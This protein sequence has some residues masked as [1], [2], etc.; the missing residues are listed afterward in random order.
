MTNSP[1]LIFPDPIQEDILYTEPSKYS[2]SGIL[3]QKKVIK[4][5]AEDIT[6]LLPITYIS[7]TFVGSQKYWATLMKDL[8]PMYMAFMKLY[9]YLY[10]ARVTIKCNHA[11]LQKIF[12]VHTFNSKVNNLG[13]EK[14]SVS[15]VTFEH[16]NGI[17]NILADCISRLRSIDLYNVLNAEIEEKEF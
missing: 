2:W 11:T 3:T 16:I 6:S 13:I 8:Y 4:I 14:F 1:F 9:Y 17:A 10:D 15:H 12:T 7:G 5:N